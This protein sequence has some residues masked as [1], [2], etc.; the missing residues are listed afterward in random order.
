MRLKTIAVLGGILIFL[1]LTGSWITTKLGDSARANPFLA[2]ADI[3]A[4]IAGQVSFLN[5]F[6]PQLRRSAGQ[7]PW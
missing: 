4:D 1:G 6:A 7:C 2:S 5:G 3:T